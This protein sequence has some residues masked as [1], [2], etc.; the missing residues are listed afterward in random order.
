MRK[1]LY[2]EGVEKK[3]ILANCITKSEYEKIYK[4][5]LS[6]PID[7]CK[8]RLGFREVKKIRDGKYFYTLPKNKHIEG[9]PNGIMRKRKRLRRKNIKIDNTMNSD[10]SQ[11]SFGDL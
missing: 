9:C 6:C 2:I 4:G 1:A 11:L 8:A 5:N 10:F 7:G 3:I